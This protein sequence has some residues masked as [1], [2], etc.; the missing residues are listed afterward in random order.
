MRAGLGERLWNLLFPARC[1]LCGEPVPPG[2]SFCPDCRRDVPEKPWERRYSV[3]GSAEG[4]LV[5]SP[6]LYEGGCREAVHR[7]K[8]RGER[9]LAKPFGRAMAQAVRCLGPFDA[10]AWVPMTEA[11]R[12][13]RGYDQSRLLAEAAAGALGIPCLSLL[14]KTRETGIQHELSRRGREENVKNAY[15]AVRRADGMTVLLVDDIVTTG[16][17]LRECAGALYRAGAK[18]VVGLCAADAPEPGAGKS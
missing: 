6:L 13:K 8:F 5:L 15:R 16:S 3:P 11:G 12:R 4:L 2:E 9:A 18:R 14:E 1:L 10:A 17:T 7:F